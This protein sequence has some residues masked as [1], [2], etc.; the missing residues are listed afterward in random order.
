ML[1]SLKL[2]PHDSHAIANT[3]SIIRLLPTSYVIIKLPIITINKRKFSTPDDFFYLYF[4]KTNR[5]VEIITMRKTHD[6]IHLL[7]GIVL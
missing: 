2:H 7:V 5:T 3:L 4:K 1:S 6:T